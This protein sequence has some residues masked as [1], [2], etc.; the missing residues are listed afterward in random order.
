[1]SLGLAA[2]SEAT[3]M[4]DSLGL[5]HSNRSALVVV[6]AELARSRLSIWP[7]LGNGSLP[8]TTLDAAP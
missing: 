7:H 3:E 6:L 4:L 5:Y 2:A 1:V 8:S